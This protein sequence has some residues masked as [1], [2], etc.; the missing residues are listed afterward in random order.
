[1]FRSLL[2]LSLLTACSTVP[3]PTDDTDT[4]ADTDTDTDTAAP[5]DADGDGFVAE[6][7]GGDDCDDGD[8]EVHP[9]A[10]EL[11]DDIDQDCDG[12]VLEDF[13]NLDGDD[14]ADCV[15]EDACAA[16]PA[17]LVVWLADGD[18]VDL[19]GAISTAGAPVSADG[20]VGA[21]LDLNTGPLA[22]ADLG[23][24]LT[25]GSLSIEAWIKTPSSTE[26]QVILSHY[27]CGGDCSRAGRTSPSAYQLAVSASGLLSLSM[28]DGDTVP[29]VPGDS[30]EGTIAVDD[31]RWHHVVGVVDGGEGTLRL[32]VD[33]VADGAAPLVHNDAS[34][35]NEDGDG[36]LDPITIGYGRAANSGD[37]GRVFQGLVDEL[38]FYDAPLDGDAVSALFGAG[39]AG[40]CDP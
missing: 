30:I 21:A 25:D 35:F 10:A 20:V 7:D 34:G 28:R 33:G 9:G 26:S 4:D 5:L 36:E 29:G 6:S 22:S 1:M 39:L 16:A 12:D 37:P 15:D 11:C 40:K 19:Q 23:P 17:G 32:Y 24:W 3:E 27:E 38:S 2:L 31:D 13:E 18:G 14:T 8:A